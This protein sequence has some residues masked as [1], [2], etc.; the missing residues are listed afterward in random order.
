[1]AYVLNE[2][3][4][5]TL[6]G[7]RIGEDGLLTPLENGVTAVD[8]GLAIDAGQL[9]FSPDG[10]SLLLTD[11]ANDLIY[12]FAVDINGRIGAVAKIRSAGK[13]PFGF[14]FDWTGD[15]YVAEAFG[16]EPL[17]AATSSYKS[18][19]TWIAWGRDRLC[20][21]QRDAGLLH[22]SKP[23]RALRLCAQFVELDH[24]ELRR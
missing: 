14:A 1:M 13:T 24:F 7:F 20:L 22:R 8:T 17:K 12:S 6:A 18:G 10:S 23:R 16:A 5:A 11:K 3:E 21:G 15:L 2:G 9:A 4:T 19:G